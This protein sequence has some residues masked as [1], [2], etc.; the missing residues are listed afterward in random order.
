MMTSYSHKLDYSPT[1]WGERLSLEPN[2]ISANIPQL[3]RYSGAWTKTCY[4]I[5]V[6]RKERK[7]TCI[8]QQKANWTLDHII[9]EQRFKA[10][11]L[12]FHNKTLN[13][14]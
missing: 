2:R 6:G 12:L 11:R 8:K 5:T 14:F 3:A 9:R 13:Y 1:L 4:V 10:T 7:D